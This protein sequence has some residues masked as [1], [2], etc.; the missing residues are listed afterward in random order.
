[1]FTFRPQWQTKNMEK[2]LIRS[3]RRRWTGIGSVACI[4]TLIAAPA[5]AIVVLGE[6]NYHVDL[7][8]GN[9]TVNPNIPGGFNLFGQTAQLTIAPA[10]IMDANAHGT[11]VGDEMGGSNV[12][13]G[14][15]W[16]VDGGIAG[17]VVPVLI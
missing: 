7:S 11:G 12:Q 14:Y 17:S 16:T 1:M 10:V 2:S 8:S 4:S 6:A 3:L 15:Y 5:Q 9:T 13:L